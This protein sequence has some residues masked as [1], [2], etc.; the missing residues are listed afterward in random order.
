MVHYQDKDYCKNK[1]YFKDKGKDKA[2]YLTPSPFLLLKLPIKG[3]RAGIDH[4]MV[5]EM[6]FGYLCLHLIYAQ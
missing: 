2:G 1:D 6:T 5:G 4:S 3:L